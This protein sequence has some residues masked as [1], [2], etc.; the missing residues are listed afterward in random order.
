MRERM[1]EFGEKE[2][3]KTKRNLLNQW[4]RKNEEG[5]LRGNVAR[6]KSRRKKLRKK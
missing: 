3:A 6:K 1:S 2:K 5:G 4:I